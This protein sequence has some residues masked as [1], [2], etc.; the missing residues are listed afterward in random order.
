MPKKDRA[1]RLRTKSKELHKA[2]HNMYERAVRKQAARQ[3]ELAASGKSEKLRLYGELL[4]ANLSS[5]PK[6]HEEHHRAQL[7]RS[8]QGSH[9]SLDLPVHAQPERAELLQELQ[10]E[11]DGGADRWTC[12]PRA[13]KRSPTSKRSCIAVRN[14]LRLRRRSMR[15]ARS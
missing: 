13:K 15:S 3:E 14:G 1:E 4:S 8:G 7:V 2:V 11:A 9:H 10:E 12:W 5:G 6:G